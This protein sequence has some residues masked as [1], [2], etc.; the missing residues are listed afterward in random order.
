MGIC[1]PT[2]FMSQGTENALF[3]PLSGT[4]EFEQQLREPAVPVD[5]CTDSVLKENQ[6]V[7]KIAIGAKVARNN[8]DPVS[9]P[10]ADNPPTPRLELTRRDLDK[11]LSAADDPPTPRL[12][13]NEQ[14]DEKDECCCGRGFKRSKVTHERVL[15]PSSLNQAGAR[16]AR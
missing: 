12:E 1:S 2:C 15:A 10:A 7:S 13:V 8:N 9:F 5:D 16:R 6:E 14:A 3:A 4:D 11:G